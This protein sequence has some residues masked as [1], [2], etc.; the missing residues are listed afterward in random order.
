MARFVLLLSLVFAQAAIAQA[1][2]CPQKF[3]DFLERF[4]TD[5]KFH[6]GAVRFPLPMSYMDVADDEPQRMKGRLSKR[7]YA[8][9]RQPWYPTPELQRDWQLTRAIEHI[10]PTRKV[11]R[12]RQSD[13]QTYSV[14]FHFQRAGCWRLVFM[15]DHSL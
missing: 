7:E 12:F 1:P 2:K 5:R 8:G 3:E 14:D 6:L 10:S 13:P 4:E 9:P 15:A 11:V